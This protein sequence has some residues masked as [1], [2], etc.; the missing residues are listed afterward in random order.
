[1]NEL[2]II[3]LVNK[4][5][6][7]D[8][9]AMEVLYNSYYKD[10]LYVCKKLN[11][12]DADAHDIAQDTFIDAFSKLSTLNDKCKFKQWVCRIANNKAL[13]L[14]KHNNVI[15]FDNIDADDSFTEIPDKEMCVEQQVIEVEVA[16][17]LRNIIEMLPLEQKITIFMFYYED[18]SIKEIAAAYNCS[19]NTVKSRLSYAKK[20][21]TQE[22]NK[23]ENNG[24][25]LRCTALLPFLYLLFTQ[26]QKAFATSV[27]TNAIPTATAVIAKT[28]KTVGA[29]IATPA[30]AVNV[31]N[32]TNMT[33]TMNIANATNAASVATTAAKTFSIG[34]LIGISVAAVV[35]ISATV[36][37]IVL[38]TNNNDNKSKTEYLSTESNDEFTSTEIIADNNNDKDNNHETNDNSEKPEY[39]TGNDYWNYYPMDT[40]SLPEITYTKIDYMQHEKHTYSANIAETFF[41]DTLETL[42]D[43]LNTSDYIQELD[44]IL[45]TGISEYCNIEKFT[46]IG[47]QKQFKVT[48]TITAYPKSN[49]KEVTSVD[50]YSYADFKPAFTLDMSTDYTNYTTPN[51]ISINFENIN[52]NR[53]TQDMT[54]NILEIIYGEEIAKYLVYAKDTDGLRDSKSISEEELYDSIKIGDTTYT[55][56][57]TIYMP[58]DANSL[59]SS[60]VTYTV[61]VTHKAEKSE[62]YYCDS[63]TSIFLPEEFQLEQYILGNFGS[64][65]TS[66]ANNFGSEY[67]QNC[68]D[69]KYEETFIDDYRYKI[70]NLPDGTVN[71]IFSL[72]SIKWCTNILNSITPT[73]D[74]NINLWSKDEALLSYQI[75]F[76][77]DMPMLSVDDDEARDYS[78][79][80]T[81]FI[82]Q[83][84]GLFNPEWDLS[85]LTLELFLEEEDISF[86]TTY[87]GKPCTVTIDYQH[88]VNMAEY[89]TGSFEIYIKPHN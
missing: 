5:L 64:T 46:N 28:M 1:M 48:K 22:V 24:I 30:P 33:N 11:L 31:V 62:S 21:I 36:V 51:K 70:Y 47:S 40:L 19:E 14:L 66:D 58:K 68:L 69:E 35:L 84:K 81:P 9:Q 8:N 78:K 25:K 67:M 45:T 16:N 15:Q 37:G 56:S 18:M 23:L 75:Q 52:I 43:K 17:T 57:R 49:V 61:E 13:N 72:S 44:Y 32:T 76:K 3:E 79:L 39:T 55:L 6:Y 29:N 89:M 74:I 50:G 4:A 86:D 80:Y 73:L 34:K 12:N 65:N 87:L 2:E 60:K 83:L 85:I 59:Y 82:N 41:T 71:T 88:G 53:D 7:R 10:V 26:E 38:L 54:F 20:F 42:L 77:G 63:Y 27:P